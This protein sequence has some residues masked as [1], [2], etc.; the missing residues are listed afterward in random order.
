[1][2]SLSARRVGGSH[3]GVV[4]P[5]GLVAGP[6]AGASGGILGRSSSTPAPGLGVPCAVFLVAKEA[7]SEKPAAA[8]KQR[9]KARK[10]LPV[11]AA[12]QMP[13]SVLLPVH[14]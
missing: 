8:I 14:R 12:Y 11:A 10:A 13:L 1:M 6:L 5:E 7:D 2:S 3:S 9:K 4:E